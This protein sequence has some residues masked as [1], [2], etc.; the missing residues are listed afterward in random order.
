[1]TTNEQ[2]LRRAI[3]KLNLI[4]L[5]TLV[6]LVGGVGGWAATVQL[7]GAVIASGLVVVESSVRKVQHPTGGV[8]GK[9]FVKQGDVVAKG[10]PLV[11][12]DATLAQSTLGIV[13]SQLDEL[14]ARQARLRAERDAADEPV[15]PEDLLERSSEPT[16][17]VAVAG[18]QKL[19]ESR[20]NARA[21]QRS[22]LRE[23]IAQTQ[24]EIRGLS[25]QRAAKEKEIAFIAEE[26]KGVSELYSKNLVSIMRYMALQRDQAKLNGDHGQLGADVARARGRIS[27][28]ELQIIQLDQDFR[29]EVLKELREI[30]GKIAELQE[31]RIAAKFQLD[32]IDIVA[33]QNGIVHQL[34]VHTEGG[35]IANGETIM[36]IV[37]REDEL[38]I[39]AKVA[40]NDVDQV[41]IGSPVQV[42]IM[43][44]NQR[45]T[46]SLA[47]SVTQ[48][49]ADLTREPASGS[50]PTQAYFLTRV[51]LNNE[52]I[53]QL[54]DLQL[55]PGMPAEVF[56]ETEQRTPLQYLIKPLQEQIARTFRER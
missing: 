33:P 45:V 23:R 5:A 8:V 26:L 24:E 38:V 39:E 55:V 10:Q 44:G 28:I 34:N 12:L 47:G 6:V 1:M 9:I 35:V 14:T 56:I 51:I 16:V 3:R 49:S 48:V 37:P 36:L 20:R 18:E 32:Q 40:P 50:Q 42:R 2:D 30:E 41:K 13:R 17:K 27:E 22:Q 25:E 7:S 11:R 46:P 15:F 29:T 52:S 21:G 54:G 53:Q 31:R 4:G 43:A 19:F